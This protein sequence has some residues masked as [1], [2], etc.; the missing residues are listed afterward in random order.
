MEEMANRA[1]TQL[2]DL[3]TKLEMET[4]RNVELETKLRNEQESNHCRESRLNLALEMAQRDLREYQEEVRRLKESIPPRDQEIES[5]RNQIKEK[6]KEL[7]EANA[8]EQILTAM[9]EQI[10]T[11]T[12]ENSQLKEQLEVKKSLFYISQLLFN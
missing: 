1:H 4:A 9:Q 6:S 7:E 3:R 10:D 2:A 12:L 11:L 8:A 5:L